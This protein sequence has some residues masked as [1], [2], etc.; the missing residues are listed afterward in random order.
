MQASPP[1]AAVCGRDCGGL[2]RD[3]RR[4]T[5]ASD[6]VPLQNSHA[7]AAAAA[8]AAASTGNAAS[9]RWGLLLAG[10]AVPA[11]PQLPAACPS[12]GALVSGACECATAGPPAP[13]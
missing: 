4:P 3:L 8:A 1:V 12:V 13:A 11:P 6:P 5:A 9:A 10:R 2:L 7:A